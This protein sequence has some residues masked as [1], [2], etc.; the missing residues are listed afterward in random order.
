[1]N[2]NFDLTTATSA[3]EQTPAVTIDEG[4]SSVGGPMFPEKGSNV[5]VAKDT[6]IFRC[7]ELHNHAAFLLFLLHRLFLAPMRA[8]LTA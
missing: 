3:T 8:A 6:A 7:A 4:I 2:D 1:M 5:T